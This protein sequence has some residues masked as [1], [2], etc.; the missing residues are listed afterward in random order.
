MKGVG[1]AELDH[2]LFVS[3]AET[4]RALH[5]WKTAFLLLLLLLLFVVSLSGLFG[6]IVRFL[7]L[8]LLFLVG[9]QLFLLFLVGCHSVHRRNQRVLG[10]RSHSPSQSQGCRLLAF[11]V[12]LVFFGI[13]VVAVFFLFRGYLNEVPL[14]E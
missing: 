8:F 14:R 12:F 4:Y 9:C 2:V 6:I 13:L 1:A 5:R 3:L 7:Q 10:H 11:F